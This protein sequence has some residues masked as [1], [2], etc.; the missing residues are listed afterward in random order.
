MK[1]GNIECEV[2]GHAGLANLIDSLQKRDKLKKD[3][4]VPTR[5]GMESYLR[6]K[7]IQITDAV[8]PM[9]YSGLAFDAGPSLDSLTTEFIPSQLFLDKFGSWADIS[10]TYM[11]KLVS[12]IMQ[13][14]SQYQ[15]AII[16]YNNNNTDHARNMYHYFRKELYNLNEILYS[17][18]VH[19]FEYP[20]TK[21]FDKDGSPPAHSKQL[22]RL[23]NGE[24]GEQGQVRTMLSSKY[25]LL[26]DMPAINAVGRALESELNKGGFYLDSANVGL[27]KTHMKFV[28]TNI[29]V[30]IDG[31]PVNYM[32]D[33]SNSEVGA[34]SFKIMEGY[35]YQ[36][37]TNGA[38]TK[39]ITSA[40]HVGLSKD[41][42]H[43]MDTLKKE[44]EL[45]WS[46]IGDSIE[47]SMTQEKMDEL[48]LSIDHGKKKTFNQ[49]EALAKDVTKQ[50]KLS[51]S[52]GLMFLNKLHEDSSHFGMNAWGAS[53]A[54]TSVAKTAKEYNRATELEEAGAKLLQVP[55]SYFT[56][57]TEAVHAIPDGNVW[58]SMG[59]LQ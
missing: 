38:I 22:F 10:Q 39:K 40:I 52:E 12:K 33:I 49:P 16:N 55:A 45:L 15:E 17:Q 57:H 14:R 46:Q 13:A 23:L 29:G 54:L 4:I 1:A 31:H 27:D 51:D 19:F 5:V 6:P 9:P 28:N 7:N 36:W 59:G 34:G 43:S 8:D 11:R 42:T 37:C 2:G 25:K 20:A 50:Y 58:S 24:N 53:N 21:R 32:L 26:D 30:E 56:K 41:E 48:A 18:A 3:V 44:G 35:F 47:A